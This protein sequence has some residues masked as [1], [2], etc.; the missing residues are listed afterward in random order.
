[1]PERRAV[2]HAIRYDG[3]RKKGEPIEDHLLDLTALFKEEGFEPI[4]ARPRFE[5]GGSIYGAE[6]W[7]F[8]YEKD[9]IEQVTTYGQELLRV[10]RRETLEGTPPWRHRDNIFKVNWS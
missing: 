9:L 6:W 2:E 3:D 1:M 5:K 10:Y 7:H 4:R 8:Q